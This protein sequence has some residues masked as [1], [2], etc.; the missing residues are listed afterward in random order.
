MTQFLA[1]DLQPPQLRPRERP[2]RRS[3]GTALA[4]VVAG[5]LNLTLVAGAGWGF[6]NSQRVADQL[7]VWDFEPTSAISRYVERSTFT[8]YGEFLFR[9]SRPNVLGGEEFEGACGGR[10]EGVGILG[11]YHPATRLITLYDVTD[12]RLDGMEEVTASHEMLHAAWHRLSDSERERVGVLL[13]A[14]A[15][16]LAGD[17]AF[18]ARM[19]F[20]ART[21][22][23]ERR[24]ELHSIIATEIADVSPALEE[25]FSLYFTD[26]QSIVHLHVVSHAVF[27]DLEARTEAVIE[28]LEAVEAQI[29]A[30]YAA[31]IA[32]SDVLSADIARFNRRR[33]N[34]EFSSQE[35]FNRERAELIARQDALDS[36]FT[37]VQALES[38]Y[39]ALLVELESLNAEAEELNRSINIEPRN[40]ER[41]G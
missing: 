33:S 23:G 35:Q 26:R 38:R 13:E 8:E 27:V 10:H 19:K 25:Y 28:Q 22:P 5:L 34:G 40:E 6:A 36:D 16:S 18:A 32:A 15:E 30:D 21:E 4:I 14:E 17:G 24:N 41:V 39:E 31:Y 1:Y 20:Y 9:A 29:E 12:P 11:C 7:T 37:A 3:V 2:V